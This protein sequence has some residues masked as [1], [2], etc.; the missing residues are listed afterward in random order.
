M[1]TTRRV[2]QSGFLLLTLAGVFVFRADA[3]RWCP[4]GGVETLYTYVVEGNLICSLGISNL[5]ILVGIVVMTMLIR[6]AFCAYVCP[7]GTI[8]ECLGRVASRFGFRPSK[9]TGLPD[10]LL[11]T[12]KYLVLIVILFF[13][14]RASELVFRG[15]DPCY[16]LISRHGIDITFWAY[17]VAGAVVIG[18]LMV[19]L[20][21]C[22]WLCPLA[23]VL[24]PFSRFAVTRV[25][26]SEESC[27]ECGICVSS[28]PMA[29]PV[30]R[31]T[32][33]SHARCLSCLSCVGSCPES[34]AKT[35]SWGPSSK[36]AYAWPQGV[37]VII[38]L[39]CVTAAV[40][41]SY[42]F[43]IPSFAK[44]RGEHPATTALVELSIHNLNCRGRA[45]LLMYFL[46]RDDIF[47]VPGY[48]NLEAWPRPGEAR[49]RITYDPSV[50]DETIIKEAIT[51]PYYDPDKNM[52]RFSPFTV[53]GYDLVEP[54][55]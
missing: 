33:V 49:A 40:S 11:S 32:E 19:I 5:Y 44:A 55:G 35:M 1:R 53:E 9:V 13:T 50:C 39:S 52:W 38:V 43:P 46:E 30:N 6:R 16:A 37:L 24:Q 54:G 2:I 45:N 29:I 51:E 42:L 36:W 27:S 20:P 25:K 10:R 31:V 7:I 26:R 21:F 48:L 4:F 22:R 47:E 34:A 18:S 8:S 3:E 15:F 17:V 12:L 14:Y 41:A 28:C 23:A